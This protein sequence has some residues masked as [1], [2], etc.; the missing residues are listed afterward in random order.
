MVFILVPRA[1]LFGQPC[2]KLHPTDEMKPKNKP[3]P[4]I[5][6]KQQL[7]N[8]DAHPPKQYV[9]ALR[10]ELDSNRVMYRKLY[11]KKEDNYGEVQKLINYMN[12][13]TYSIEFITLLTKAFELE[14][15]TM[16]EFFLG[17][18]PQ[19]ADQENK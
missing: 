1:L 17:T 11:G 8:R 5:L 7:K 2:F 3:M 14:N 4:K 15:V 6:N 16:G 13:G 18:K 9:E 10:E 19:G 12:R